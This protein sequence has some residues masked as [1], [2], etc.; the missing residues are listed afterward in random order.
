MWHSDV[1]AA[2]KEYK[3]QLP[4]INGFFAVAYVVMVFLTTESV[5]GIVRKFGDSEM[6]CTEYSEDTCPVCL[7]A[8]EVGDPRGP[9]EY[10]C[11]EWGEEPCQRCEARLP[12]FPY[13]K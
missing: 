10:H 6:P 12:R 13:I 5:T 11:I 1:L 9:E 4:L 8:E 3:E 2:R 7:S